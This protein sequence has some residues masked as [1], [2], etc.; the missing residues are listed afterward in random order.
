MKIFL[1]CL[2][3]KPC[4]SVGTNAFIISD[5]QLLNRKY[6]GCETVLFSSNP[7]I[8]RLQ[9]GYLPYKITY[10]KRSANQLRAMFQ[11]RR[12][13]R[14]VDAVI[15]AW[16]DGYIT[17]PPYKLLRKSIFLKKKNKP[18]ILFTSSIGPFDG[19]FKDKLAA[20]GLRLFDVVT[21]R[22]QITYDYLK[23][24]RLKKLRIVHDTAFVLEPC[25]SQRSSELLKQTGLDG[26]RFIGLNIS[27]LLHDIFV[28]QGKS[29][30][31]LIVKYISWIREKIGLPVVLI[32][33]QIYPTGVPH[34]QEEY[35]SRDGDDRYVIEMILKHMRDKTGVYALTQEVM[36]HELKG[37]IGKSEML[38]GGRMHSII[39]GVSLAVPSLVMQ[40]SHKSGGMM[41]LLDMDDC[42]WDINN[43]LDDLITKTHRLWKEREAVHKKYRDMMPG[44]YKEIY[45]LADEIKAVSGVL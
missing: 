8:D 5:I 38:I 45:G 27:I 4:M 42:V 36:P 37:V 13:I 15:S 44:I 9:F 22:D 40:Y 34:T 11:L 24:Y 16:G 18:L 2:A 31:E 29:Y 14:K 19:G 6:P 25:K 28:Q 17:V 30:L 33:H 23:P 1:D 39:A 43:S 20:I 12:I 21:V 10:V 32:P 41:Q 7:K 35:S 3:S 26:E